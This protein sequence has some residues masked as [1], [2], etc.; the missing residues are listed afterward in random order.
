MSP[1]ARGVVLR[2]LNPGVVIRSKFKSEL[3]ND[4]GMMKELIHGSKL[5]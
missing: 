1:D 3:L 5:C 2:R 4:Q